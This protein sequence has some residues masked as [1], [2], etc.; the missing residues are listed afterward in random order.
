MPFVVTRPGGGFHS[1]WGWVAKPGGG[2][3][4]SRKEDAED[5]IR[6]N[7]LIGALVQKHEPASPTGAERMVP[8]GTERLHGQ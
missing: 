6:Q 5:H 1:L 4:F 3:S 7:R 2:F 8:F